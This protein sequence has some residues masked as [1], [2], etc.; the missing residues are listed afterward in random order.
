MTFPQLKIKRSAPPSIK[1]EYSTEHDVSLKKK[2]KKKKKR[3][4]KNTQENGKSV[5]NLQ[6]H[7]KG[8][9]CR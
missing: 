6:K 4:P 7:I 3:K 2:E 1:T 8:N 9:T 5:L